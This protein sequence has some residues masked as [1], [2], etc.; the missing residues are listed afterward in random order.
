MRKLSDAVMDWSSS[1]NEEGV[2]AETFEKREDGW[3][4]ASS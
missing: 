3:L 4:S 1:T 2:T